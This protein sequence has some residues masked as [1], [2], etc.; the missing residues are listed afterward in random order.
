MRSNTPSF[1]LFRSLQGL[2][3][4]VGIVIVVSFP[5]I[6]LVEILEF[7]F[8]VFEDFLLHWRDFLLETCHALESGEEH[9][10]A[11]NVPFCEAFGFFY[12]FERVAFEYAPAFGRFFVEF[13]VFALDHF[14][15]PK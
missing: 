8:Y 12:V 2:I 9:V 6:R 10:E 3:T 13:A 7:S 5:A 4:A 14:R 1:E 15:T 11:E